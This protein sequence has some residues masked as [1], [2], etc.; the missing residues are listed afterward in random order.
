MSNS[1]IF[2]IGKTNKKWFLFDPAY[3]VLDSS[4]IS[5]GEISDE[6][7]FPCEDLVAIED[8]V[9]TSLEFILNKIDADIRSV[10]FSTYGASFVHIDQDGVPL[11]PLYN[12]LKPYPGSILDKFYKTYGD[13][14]KIAKITASPQ[15]GMLNSG[16]Q[17]YWLKSTRPDVFERIQ[18]SLHLPQYL[19]FLITGIPV[20]EFT[21]IGC[22]TGLWDF[23]RMDYHKWV[24]QE[25]IDRILPPIVET[26]TSFQLRYNDQQL[27][28]GV[29]IHDSSSA[30]IPYLKGSTDPFLLL[31]TGTWSIAL[32]PYS[33]GQLTSEDL[34]Y[35]CLNYL[36]FDGRPVRAS[37]L[38]LGNEYALQIKKLYDHFAV[39]GD[40][41]AD[42]K[43][44]E[45][46]LKM[47]T[48]K[49]EKVFRFESIKILNEQ[50]EYSKLEMFNTFE[51]AIH[52]LML[53]LIDLQVEALI[54]VKGKT[55]IRKIY[56]DGGFAKN[57]LFIPMLS[58]RFPEIEICTINYPQGSALGAA[59]VFN[60]KIGRENIFQDQ[61]EKEL[62]IGGRLVSNKTKRL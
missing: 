19:C 60:N 50:P 39:G 53:E 40:A 51:E 48:S 54:R 45:A 43:L 31:S 38:F 2:D 37:R 59:M 49:K 22:H 42:V 41:F 24:Y 55:E 35:D 25:G 3:N 16:L 6:D 32:N 14:E 33:Q 29:G 7:G 36:R 61:F 11:T 46:L 8:W 5:I 52:Q 34:S 28:F 56:V 23:E 18:W 27:N 58:F 15:L 13:A 21:S 57:S 20:S 4:Q 17:L 62:W 9:K 1:L 10:N 47:L 30:L 12:Y 26:E 44:D